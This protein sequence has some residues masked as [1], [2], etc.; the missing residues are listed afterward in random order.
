M[1]HE[2][3]ILKL[4]QLRKEVPRNRLQIKR[5]HVQVEYVMTSFRYYDNSDVIVTLIIGN[6]H[7]YLIQF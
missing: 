6:I 1:V 7:L 2:F 3:H 5:S 4:L